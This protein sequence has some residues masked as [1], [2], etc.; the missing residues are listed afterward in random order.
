MER[1]EEDFQKL[2][3]G[4]GRDIAYSVVTGLK[5]DLT[6]VQS[7]PQ[8]LQGDKDR[9]G[10]ENGGEVSNGDSGESENEG[11]FDA[12]GPAEAI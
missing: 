6:G 1:F 4:E 10:S 8:L 12:A 2:S 9:E 5:P 11:L 3:V 7:V